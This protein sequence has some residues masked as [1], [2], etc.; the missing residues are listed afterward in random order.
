MDIM[1]MSISASTLIAAI[2]IV[3]AVALHKL[4]KKTFLVLWEVATLRLLIPFSIPSRFSIYTGLDMLKSLFME[5]TATPSPNGVAILPTNMGY[6]PA[7]GAE[8]PTT[9]PSAIE[10]IW[11]LGMCA[12]LLFF[13]ISYIKCRREFRMSLPVENDV[14][15]RWLREHP[16][17]RPVQIRQTD[18]IKAPLTYGILHPVVLLSKK[19]DWAEEEQLR[20][21]L[22]HEYVHIRRFDTLTKLALTAAVCVHWFNPFVWVMFILANRDIELS[23]DETVVKAFGGNVKSTYA[24]TLIELEE[25]KGWL[26]PLVSNFSKTAIEERITAIMKVKKTSLLAGMLAL[27]VVVGTVTV[28]ATNTANA[29]EKDV[30]ADAYTELERRP[31]LNVSGKDIEE[32]PEL[33]TPTE[34]E[35]PAEIASPQYNSEGGSGVVSGEKQPNNTVTKDT[36]VHTPAPDN[37]PPSKEPDKNASYVYPLNKNGETYGSAA[38]GNPDL[39]LAL[40]TEGQTGYIR[41][42]EVPGANVTNL[43]EAAEYMEWIITQPSTIM[44]PLYDQEGNVIGEFG[45]SNT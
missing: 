25:T 35:N 33:L 34:T 1:Q 37:V 18:R 8:M 43:E 40:G 7:I 27:T 29:A 20:Y 44:I 41:E 6:T 28:F 30:P 15:S 23:C 3:R 12:F 42:S 13:I 21:V 17:H 11:L 16:L 5:K 32:T 45:V 22:A 39:T 31:S 36:P 24:R 26:S 14:A 19:M 10:I 2:V 4:P 38:Y 9:S